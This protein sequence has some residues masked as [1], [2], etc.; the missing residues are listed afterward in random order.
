MFSTLHQQKDIVHTEDDLVVRILLRKITNQLANMNIL[1][2]LD[3]LA[4]KF[5]CERT[6]HRLSAQLFRFELDVFSNKV[7]II[8]FKCTI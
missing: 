5:D 3:K 6:I 1:G 4:K 2:L 7:K 8:L